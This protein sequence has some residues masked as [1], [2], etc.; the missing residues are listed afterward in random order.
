MDANKRSSSAGSSP[1]H[2]VRPLPRDWARRWEKNGSL[3][4]ERHFPIPSLQLLAKS[5]V[6]QV[7]QRSQFSSF[8]F[9]W[10]IEELISQPAPA[11]GNRRTKQ[12]DKTKDKRK[13]KTKDKRTPSHAGSENYFSDA[14]RAH[15]GQLKEFDWRNVVIPKSAE[16]S[17]PNDVLDKSSLPPDLGSNFMQARIQTQFQPNVCFGCWANALSTAY[18]DRLRIASGGQ[19]DISPGLQVFMNFPKEM[20]EKKTEFF[21]K[22]LRKS[23]S[24]N[25]SRSWGTSRWRTG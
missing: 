4:E 24:P 13:D 1:H 5:D 17:P 18:S 8:A 12:K 20:E 11:G 3:P 6:K 22:K 7:A 25:L 9:P 2:E 23:G 21:F 14:I 15:V 10:I 16:S 19:I